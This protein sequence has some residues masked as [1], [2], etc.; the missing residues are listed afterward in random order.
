VFVAPDAL[1]ST[2]E[3]GDGSL[4]APMP[5]TMLSVDVALGD[6]VVAGQTLGVLEAMKMELALTAPFDGTVTS[7]ATL[8]SQVPLGHVLFTVEQEGAG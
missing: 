3:V 1:V 6:A 2:A 4:A 8:G 5:G 7:V